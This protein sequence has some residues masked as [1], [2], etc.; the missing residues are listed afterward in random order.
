MEKKKFVCIDDVYEFKQYKE[1]LEFGK[2]CAYRALQVQGK[3]DLDINFGFILCLRGLVRPELRDRGN[4]GGG[5]VSP[6][7]WHVWCE[8]DNHIYDS[9]RAFERFGVNI[10]DIQTVSLGTIPPVQSVELFKKWVVKF[11]K[12]LAYK[13]YPSVVYVQ[14]TA[15]EFNDFGKYILKTPDDFNSMLDDID[16]AYKITGDTQN[17]VYQLV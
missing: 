3:T 8:D 14:G 5:Y 1:G 2:D 16:E 15:L 9:C 17:Q 7:A 13:G 6:Y 4:F 10:G 11:S 12:S